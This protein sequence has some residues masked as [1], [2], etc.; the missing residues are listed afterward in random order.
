MPTSHTWSHM[1][2]HIDAIVLD[3]VLHDTYIDANVPDVVI[4]ENTYQKSY[5]MTYVS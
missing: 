4:H 5:V 2:F 3:R 1:L